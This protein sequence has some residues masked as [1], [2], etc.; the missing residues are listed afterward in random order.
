MCVQLP[1]HLGVAPALPF[2]LG[3]L[4][5]DASAEL[6]QAGLHLKLRNPAT[7]N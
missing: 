4:R 3:K 5:I 1:Y 6:L 7:R 2:Q